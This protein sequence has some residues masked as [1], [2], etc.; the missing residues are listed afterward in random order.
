VLVKARQL[1]DLAG[2]DRLPVWAQA[3][4]LMGADLPVVRVVA[5]GGRKGGEGGER[6][7]VVARFVVHELK[8]DL[9][10]ELLEMLVG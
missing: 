8:A 1:A 2:G 5:T 7:A 10:P 3:R 4:A 6:A 9:F